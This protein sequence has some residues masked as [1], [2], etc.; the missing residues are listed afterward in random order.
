MSHTLQATIHKLQYVLPQTDEETTP[1]SKEYN[2]FIQRID[3]EENTPTIHIISHKWMPD[4][5]SVNA[6]ISIIGINPLSVDN[7]NS[8]AEVNINN[9]QVFQEQ[10][11][12][13]IPL[14]FFNQHCLQCFHVNTGAN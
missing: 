9:L 6:K 11:I 10:L 4:E 8:N 13:P 7:L 2:E 1:T 14:E 5:H 12:Q 3:M